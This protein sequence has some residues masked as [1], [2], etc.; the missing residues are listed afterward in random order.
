MSYTPSPFCPGDLVETTEEYKE[1]AENSYIRFTSRDKHTYSKGIVSEILTVRHADTKEP[2]LDYIKLDNGFCA[3]SLDFQKVSFNCP[4]CM[5]ETD[6]II[7]NGD[8]FFS[9]NN[10]YTCTV[11]PFF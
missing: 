4:D 6:M 5:E 7:V 2:I 3:R 1:W 10:I 11:C 9:C 8:A